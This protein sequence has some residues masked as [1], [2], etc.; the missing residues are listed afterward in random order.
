M[1]KKALHKER[2]GELILFLTHTYIHGYGKLAHLLGTSPL[3]EENVNPSQPL[4]SPH[5]RGNN[6]QATRLLLPQRERERERE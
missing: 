2:R 5:K 6:K 1:Y 4:L 3:S